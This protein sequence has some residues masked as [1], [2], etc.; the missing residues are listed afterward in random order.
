MNGLVAFIPPFVA[1]IVERILM[2]GCAGFGSFAAAF[3]ALFRPEMPGAAA[4]TQPIPLHG[5]SF[6]ANHNKI[7]M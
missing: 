5:R 4:T 3:A 1:S 2:F 7:T 6:F